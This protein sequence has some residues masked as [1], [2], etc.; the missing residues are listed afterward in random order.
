M[1]LSKR[2][3]AFVEEF[4]NLQ[5]LGGRKDSVSFQTKV[6]KLIKELTQLE[7]FIQQL[8]LFSENESIDELNP[9]YIQYLNIEFY[10]GCLYSNY[11]LN[12]N[13]N[14]AVEISDG[15]VSQLTLNR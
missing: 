4:N 9:L 6:S 12:P 5:S 1:S 3:R 8:N 14:T 7:I 2:F 10:Y 15:Q 13:T 11:L